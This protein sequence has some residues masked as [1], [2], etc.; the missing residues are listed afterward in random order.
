MICYCPFLQADTQFS[1]LSEEG[2]F[3]LFNWAVEL[4]W[5]GSFSIVGSP[6]NIKRVYHYDSLVKQP[7]KH[8]KCLGCQLDCTCLFSFSVSLM[9]L[10]MHRKMAHIT[11]G[12][13][14]NVNH[15]ES[16]MSKCSAEPLIISLTDRI[17]MES[18]RPVL[19]VLG[20]TCVFPLGA[21]KLFQPKG[22]PSV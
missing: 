13:L 1:E 16:T 22:L 9:W 21:I 15:P 8:Y 4:N 10:L 2:T 6:Y 19:P 7:S 17:P 3:R 20:L 11:A 5:I 18:N 12:L 14:L